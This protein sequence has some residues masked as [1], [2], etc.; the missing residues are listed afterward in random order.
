MKG[1]MERVTGSRRF[2]HVSPEA[3]NWKVPVWLTFLQQRGSFLRSI[4]QLRKQFTLTNV[5]ITHT[6]KEAPCRTVQPHCCKIKTSTKLTRVYVY[7]KQRP[8]VL[9]NC[10]GRTGY[11]EC[12]G[13]GDCWSPNLHPKPNVENLPQGGCSVLFLN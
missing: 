6:M 5:S 8:N 3:K 10:L 13:M 1:K 11:L 4:T 2:Y 7:Y 9:C 12:V